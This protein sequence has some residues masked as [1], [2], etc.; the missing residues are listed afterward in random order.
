VER[1][2]PLLSNAQQRKHRA[3][4]RFMMEYCE[5]KSWQWELQ[6]PQML[7]MNVL[8]LLV[9]P[10]ISRQHCSIAR[11]QGSLYCLKENDT[12][13]VANDVWPLSSEIASQMVIK[14]KG[15]NGFLGNTA[16]SMIH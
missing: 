7:H 4:I 8:H 10:N 9:F 14:A 16:G 3:F 1:I 6:A 2:V 12:W 5:S 15:V 13:E 11:E